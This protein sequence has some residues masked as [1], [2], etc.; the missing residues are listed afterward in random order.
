[1]KFDFR[2][3]LENIPKT[4]KY[5]QTPEGKAERFLKQAI[6]TMAHKQI[7]LE[8][9]GEMYFGLGGIYFENEPLLFF[10]YVPKDKV[11]EVK[12]DDRGIPEKIQHIAI[13]AERIKDEDEGKNLHEGI[14]V[15]D[16]I[17]KKLKANGFKCEDISKLHK[18]RDQNLCKYI[19]IT[20]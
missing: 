6:D 14:S 12:I 19:K 8:E 11:K 2:Q 1:M 9:I 3:A 10:S 16:V 7:S 4:I 15:F 18:K 17:E 20:F 5:Y 13:F